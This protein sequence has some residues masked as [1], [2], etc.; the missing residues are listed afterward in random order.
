MGPVTLF[1]LPGY[2][3]KPA[4]HWNRAD[5]AESGSKF[6]KDVYN[7]SYRQRSSTGRLSLDYTD[8]ATASLR[9]LHCDSCACRI[10]YFTLKG[11][12]NGLAQF[13]Q[14]LGSPHTHTACPRTYEAI[15]GVHVLNGN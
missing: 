12:Q 9:T 13:Q 2:R 3:A 7:A 6:N 8:E 5:R 1:Q 11:C 15:T 10:I 4:P 14:A